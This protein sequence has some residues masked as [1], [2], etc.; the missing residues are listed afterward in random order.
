MKCI[1]TRIS[2]LIIKKKKKCA[3]RCQVANFHPKS[4]VGE[5]L[6]PFGSDDQP[7]IEE[8]SNKVESQKHEST[9]K[10]ETITTFL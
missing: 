9:K 10:T 6:H 4:I 7:L 2:S 5:L 1:H 8:T 3:Y